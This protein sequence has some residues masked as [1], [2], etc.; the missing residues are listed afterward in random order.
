MVPHLGG[1]ADDGG[2]LGGAAHRGWMAVKGNL[3]GDTD[4]ALL[5]ET[6]RGED[7]AL[8]SDRDARDS[9]LPPEVRVL[10]EGQ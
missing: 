10:V 1:T 6:E 8:Q 4:L 3:A 7:M 5:A 2:T 9:E